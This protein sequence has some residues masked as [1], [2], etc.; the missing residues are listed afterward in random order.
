MKTIKKLFLNEKGTYSFV[1]D[2]TEIQNSLISDCGRFYYDSRYKPSESFLIDRGFYIS[3]TGGGYT[4]WKQ[5]FYLGDKHIFMLIT[6]FNSSHECKD[7]EEMIFE[8]FESKEYESIISWTT[9]NEI[10]IHNSKLLPFEDMSK[11]EQEQA[12]N[13]Q[14]AIEALDIAL[15]LIQKRIGIESGDYASNFFDNTNI[16]DQFMQYIK[17]E[18]IN[19]MGLV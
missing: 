14:L 17:Q 6:N 8:L 13:E 10:T 16:V 7:N 9:K 19:K 11:I 3:E 15:G 1:C 2:H 4:A 5:E 12:D 18:K